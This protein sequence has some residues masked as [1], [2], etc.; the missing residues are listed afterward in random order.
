MDIMRMKYHFYI[1]FHKNVY[2]ECYKDLDEKYL[3]NCTFFGV[4]SKIQKYVPDKLR[5]KVILE[6][7]LPYYNPL[8]QF[9]EFCENSTL[10]HVYKNPQ[11]CNYDYVGFFQYDMILTN[12][13]F[14]TIDSTLESGSRDTVFYFLKENSYR[15]LDQI[16]HLQG[17][18]KIVELYNNIFHTNHSLDFVL[19][20]DIV[21]L[22]C[23]LLPK[24]VFTR[25]MDFFEKAFPTMFEL[26]G[27]EVRHLPFHLERMHGIFLLFQH[28]EGHISQ[29]VPMPG[30]IHSNTLKDEEF[31]KNLYAKQ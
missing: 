23:F 29:F 22:H 14:A 15:H 6:R 12:S 3:E 1:I 4:N 21:L 13:V 30:L 16:I 9:A 2:E 20:N 19:I 18:Q 26:L 7:N 28:Q 31:K 10:L 17:W 11:L 5:T 24:S 27:C 8:W 25:M